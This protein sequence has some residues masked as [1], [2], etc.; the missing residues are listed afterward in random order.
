MKATSTFDHLKSILALPFIAI[1][2]VPSLLLWLIPGFNLPFIEKLPPK[3]SYWIGGIL[4]MIGIPLF[5]Q[6]INLFIK[7]GEGTLAPWDPT[8]NLVVKSLYRHM[9]N[10][11]I[12]GVAFILFAECFLFKSS[13]ILLWALFFVL[14]NHVYFILKEEPDLEKRFGTAYHA[15]KQQVPRW[16]PR[17]KGWYPERENQA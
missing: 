6:S 9:R 1:V 14:L 2:V 11:M 16:I 12:T 5:I 13:V 8:K 10:P 3:V 17:L 4:L 7:I 15:Y